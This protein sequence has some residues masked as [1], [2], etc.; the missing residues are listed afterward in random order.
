M[1]QNS[2]IREV[3]EVLLS[4]FWEVIGDNF[5]CEICFERVSHVIVQ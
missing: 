5:P 3:S 1:V 4:T 2:Q